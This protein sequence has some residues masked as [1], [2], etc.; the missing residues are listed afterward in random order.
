[1]IEDLN[2][3]FEKF[4]DEYIKFDRIEKPL[5][6]RPDIAA[7]MLLHNLVPQGGRDMVSASEH[8]EIFLDVELE[9][10]AKVATE[11]DILYLVRCGV[12][13]SEYD[14]LAMFT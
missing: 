9:D 7:F 8:D 12:R 14:C 10:L 1:M 2:E 3:V 11:E 6:P 5:H 13:L 4:N